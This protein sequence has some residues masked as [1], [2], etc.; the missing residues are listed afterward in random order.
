M[1]NSSGG[2][3]NLEKGV[4]PVAREAHTK[5]LRESLNWISRSNS[6]P[7]QTSGD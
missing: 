2:F 4:Q 3:R 7:S 5:W 1:L 6:R